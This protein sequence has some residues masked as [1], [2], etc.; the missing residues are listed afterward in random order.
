MIDPQAP[1]HIEKSTDFLG[2]QAIGTT[3]V[4]WPQA[5]KPLNEPIAYSDGSGGGARG[6]SKLVEDA[7]HVGGDGAAANKERLRDLAI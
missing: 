7:G 1:G 2:N 6:D 4:L 5:V 3:Y